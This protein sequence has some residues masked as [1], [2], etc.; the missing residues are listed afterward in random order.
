MPGLEPGI[1]RNITAGESSPFLSGTFQKLAELQLYD[2]LI[3]WLASNLKIFL[4]PM[5]WS[6][7]CSELDIRLAIILGKEAAD[8]WTSSSLSLDRLL[9]VFQNADCDHERRIDKIFRLG[10]PRTRKSIDVGD[11]RKSKNL[12]CE[13]LK[14]SFEDEMFGLGLLATRIR[15][16]HSS[17]FLFGGIYVQIS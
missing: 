13:R 4:R 9:S 7:G 11:V 2:I 12:K 10:F 17:S 6:N 3:A 1:H 5:E 14:V 15:V 8:F 16:G